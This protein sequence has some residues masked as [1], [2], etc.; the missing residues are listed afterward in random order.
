[1]S[2]STGFTTPLALVFAA[3][4]LWTTPAKAWTL[5]GWNNLGM[6]CMDADYAVFS[7]LPPYNTIHA[8]LIDSI[9]E[10]GACPNM[11]VVVGGGVF[12]RAQGLAEE[13]GADLWVKTPR[14][15]VE[16][17]DS[18]QGRRATAEQRTVGRNRRI[19]KAA[20]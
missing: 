18:Q 20:A 1:M 6:H 19:G 16:K 3:L 5:V 4:V 15:L 2:R 8:Q 13:I 14:E 11:Q 9:R 10:I 17:L 7:L 12:N